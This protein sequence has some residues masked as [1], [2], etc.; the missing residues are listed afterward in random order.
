MS[1]LAPI[2][3]RTVPGLSLSCAMDICGAYSRT[4]CTCTCHRKVKTS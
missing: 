2:P 4:D 1:R 3:L